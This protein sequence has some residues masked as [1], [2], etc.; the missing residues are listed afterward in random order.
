MFVIF[1]WQQKHL[2]RRRLAAP[3]HQFMTSLTRAGSLTLHSSPQGHTVNSLI[4]HAEGWI[5]KQ[6]GLRAGSAP[7]NDALKA[8]MRRR[9][10]VWQ[11]GQMGL[12]GIKMN[13]SH[14]L[15]GFPHDRLWVAAFR[16]AKGRRRLYCTCTCSTGRWAWPGGGRGRRPAGVSQT[17]RRSQPPAKR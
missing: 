6:P 4:C 5:A 13:T 3:N 12:G 15:S 17:Q 8:G 14:P 9:R 7:K 16:W 2:K 10:T 1:H 11:E